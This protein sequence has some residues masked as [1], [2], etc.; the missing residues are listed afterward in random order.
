ML[1]HVF[2]GKDICRD[3]SVTSTRTLD[4]LFLI[5]IIKF[6]SQFLHAGVYATCDVVSPKLSTACPFHAMGMTFATAFFF[7][8]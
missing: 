3:P 7:G 6:D 2:L 1:Q 8:L 4:G 5:A